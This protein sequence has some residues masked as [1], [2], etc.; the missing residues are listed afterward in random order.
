MKAQINFTHFTD[1]RSS[2]DGFSIVTLLLK[3]IEGHISNESVCAS[4]SGALGNLFAE[5]SMKW[6]C[7]L[8]SLISQIFVLLLMD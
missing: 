5:L 6:K 7:K 8:I 2:V 4:S 1:V 3:V